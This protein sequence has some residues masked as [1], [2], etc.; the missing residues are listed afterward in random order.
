MTTRLVSHR[1][2]E[3]V[4][5]IALHSRET[6]LHLYVRRRKHWL[7]MLDLGFGIPFGC[8][9]ELKGRN[10]RIIKGQAYTRRKYIHGSP[11]PKISKFVMGDMKGHY[12]YR[13]SLVCGAPVQ[14]RHNALE[15]ARV[16][17]N[18]VLLDA[19][20]ETG[21]RIHLKVY[22]HVV[23]RENKMIATAGA[24]R[25]QEGMR[26]AFGKPIG[27]AARVKAN[28]TLLDIF[29]NENALEHAKKALKVSATKLPVST[30]ITAEKVVA[31]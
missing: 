22:P 20:G 15:A 19:I 14:I 3:D 6:A 30:R 2:L 12:D 25:L 16:A 26:R 4:Q 11:P 27:L 5:C 23:L 24:D 8:G 1:A 9:Q 21:Y 10:Y 29:V 28:Q 31:A 7:F 18:K 13:V 17:A